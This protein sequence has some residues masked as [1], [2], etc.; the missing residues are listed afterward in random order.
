[1]SIDASA[2]TG[3]QQHSSL[4]TTSCQYLHP[5]ANVHQCQEL[6]T[7]TCSHCSSWFC[8]QHGV[9]H[10]QDLK[11]KIRHLLTETKVSDYVREERRN[12]ISH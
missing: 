7:Y 9:Q 11:E 10:Q 8:L 4:N 6:S 1:M 12:H 3:E 2:R 5:F